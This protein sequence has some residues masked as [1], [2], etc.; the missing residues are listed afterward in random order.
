MRS[1]GHLPAVVTVAGRRPEPVVSE[2]RGFGDRPPAP[3]ASHPRSL[4]AARHRVRRPEHRPADGVN[5]RQREWALGARM[6]CAFQPISSRAIY[7]P[8]WRAAKASRYGAHLPRGQGGNH[9]AIAAKPS[10]AARCLPASGFSSTSRS[11]PHWNGSTVPEA[12]I[13]SSFANPLLLASYRLGIFTR[14]T[15]WRPSSLRKVSSAI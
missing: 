7:L 9:S 13:T 11:L 15:R 12:G 8:S 14:M 10:R 4:S 2:L 1:K 6:A 5:L 3:S